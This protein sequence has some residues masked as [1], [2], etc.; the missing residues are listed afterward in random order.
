MVFN[1]FRFCLSKNKPSISVPVYLCDCME[2]APKIFFI[3]GEASGDLHAG[4]LAVA[5]KH[6]SPNTVMRGWGGDAME[7]AGV[8]LYKHVRELAFMGVWEVLKNLWTIRGHFSEAKRQIMDFKPDVLVLV[9][10]G[11]FNLRMAEWAHKQGIKVFYFILP[12]VWASRVGRLQKLK[13]FTDACYAILPFEPAFYEKYGMMV[14]YFGHPLLD[15]PMFGTIE[16]LTE[17]LPLLA[18]LPGSRHAEIEKMLPLM[19]ETASAFPDLTP[20]V[21][22][23]PGISEGFLKKIIHEDKR[24]RILENSQMVELRGAKAALVTSGTATLQMALLGIPQVVCYKTEPMFYNIAKWIIRVPYISL[25]NLIMQ[26]AVV[27]E[28][29]QDECTVDALKHEIGLLLQPE[30]LEALR[31][32]YSEL[33]K[34]LGEAGACERVAEDMMRRLEE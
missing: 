16:P 8:Q 2:T 4:R 9:D 11:G 14:Q 13:A 27:K 32:D 26:K 18:L 15:Q 25:V 20:V 28:L 17:Q 10:Y 22:Q 12:Q 5:L 29:V 34:A 3:A 33:R 31:H 23:A 7:Q 21:L 30:H 1:N 6:L 19:L 24:I